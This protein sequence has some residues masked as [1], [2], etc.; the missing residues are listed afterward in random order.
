LLFDEGQDCD[1][2]ILAKPSVLGGVLART[3]IRS[4]WERLVGIVIA[5]Q[6]ERQILE[7]VLALRAAGRFAGGL[8]GRQ[9]QCDEDANDRDDDQELDERE[10]SGLGA[11]G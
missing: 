2:P 9:Q 5:V 4:V 1:R 8:D 10:R 11:G 6:R 3:L 7:V